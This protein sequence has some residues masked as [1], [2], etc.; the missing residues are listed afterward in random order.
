MADFIFDAPS[1]I[2]ALGKTP[3]EELLLQELESFAMYDAENGG[4]VA[5]RLRR[6]NKST[7]VG[8]PIGY[9]IGH[10]Y[11]AV[12]FTFTHSISYSVHQ[13]V[14]LWHYGS[15][16]KLRLDHRDQ[17][18][19]NNRIE[20]LR[21]ISHNDNIRNTKK[22]FQPMFGISWCRSSYIIRFVRNQVCQRYGSYPILAQAQARRDELMLELGYWDHIPCLREELERRILLRL[23]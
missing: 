14:W 17:N 3:Y 7:P 16:S 15:W 11:L 20:N 19:I 2:R 13:L 21:A 10:G 22:P 12:K 4:F 18:K 8:S 5:T 23:S 6:S 1:G 9:L